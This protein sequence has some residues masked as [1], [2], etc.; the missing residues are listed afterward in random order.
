MFDLDGNT[1]DSMYVAWMLKDVVDDFKR[2]HQD[3]VGAKLIYACNRHVSVSSKHLMRKSIFF[4]SVF[5]Y[6]TRDT[7]E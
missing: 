3:F 1:Y 6:A 4:S 2:A 7:Y 5:V